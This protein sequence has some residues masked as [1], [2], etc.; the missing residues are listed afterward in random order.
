MLKKYGV[1]RLSV[2]PQTM[3]DATLELIGRSH[4]SADIIAAFN[5][6]RDMG[7][8]NINMDV[9]AGLPGE[10]A[11]DMEHTLDEI[12]KLAPEN[13][14]VHTLALKRSSRLV[15]E[16]EK[17]PMPEAGEVEHMVHMGSEAAARL[18]MRP[19]YMYR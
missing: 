9:I 19:Y 3:N 10:H 18:G 12:I 11:A 4:K 7:F 15:T 16:G 5:M 8:D 14:T 1:S 2:N 17:Y 6:A 13:L